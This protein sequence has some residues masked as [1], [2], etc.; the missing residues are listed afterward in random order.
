MEMIFITIF[1]DMMR[2]PLDAGV[3]GIARRKGAADY[4]VVNLRD[5]AEDKHGTVD[6]YPYGGGPGM[7]LMA[8]PLVKAVE[9]VCGD[10]RSETVSVIMLSPCGRLFSQSMAEE[11]AGKKKLVF[12]CGRYKGIDERVGELTGSQMVS[13]GD[14]VLSGGELPSLVIADAVARYLSLIHI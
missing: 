4:R 3:L 6:D 12:I 9:S 11:F 14:Y 13:I 1:P 5:F 2:E 7:I 8:P 10:R